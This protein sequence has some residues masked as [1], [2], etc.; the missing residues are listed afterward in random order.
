MGYSYDELVKSF[1][2]KGCKLLTTEEEYNVMKQENIRFPKYY[3]TASCGC[4]NIV[5]HHIFLNRNTGMIC[6]KCMT[7]KN[8]KIKKEE[9]IGIKNIEL[10]YNSIKYFEELIKEHFEIIKCF[11]GC[12]ADIVMRPVNCKE[13]IW[14]GI[15][16]KSTNRNE[17]EY[18][19][20]LDNNYNNLILLCICFCDKRIWAIP[21]SIVE[22]NKNKISIGLKKS[23]YNK[24]ELTKEDIFEKLQELY[25]NT[26]KF[27][28]EKFNIPTNIYQQRE[29]K[30]RKYRE[31][32]LNFINFIDNCMEGMVWDFKIGNK[33]IQEKVGCI[34]KN[35]NNSYIFG[36]TKNNGFIDK[37]R[38]H[39][40]Y[41]VGDNDFYWLN[42]EG[43]KYFYVIPEKA[44]VENGFI[45]NTNKRVLHCNTTIKNA[46]YNNYLF[47]YDNVDKKRLL[48]LLELL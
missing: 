5:H 6:P 19:F 22:D 40:Q 44:L 24:Y 8:A 2:D 36:L 11:D 43:K 31:E 12:N 20:H 45:C 10:E 16:V 27:E 7:T 42:P 48:S 38:Q 32:K 34:R 17:R 15:Q 13:N 35:T 47:E 4:N 14:V 25:N 1:E 39:I 18:G 33:K 3:Y 9:K 21:Y 46:W 41:E 37:K 29:Q 30:Y 23:K 26:K 28:F